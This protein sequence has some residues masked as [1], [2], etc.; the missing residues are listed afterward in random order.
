MTAHG[1]NEVVPYKDMNGDTNYRAVIF[2]REG[3]KFF[4]NIVLFDSDG[5]ITKDIT[6]H[7]GAGGQ[8]REIR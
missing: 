4:K 8:W 3:K 1:S 6:Y 2:K 7:Q 5:V